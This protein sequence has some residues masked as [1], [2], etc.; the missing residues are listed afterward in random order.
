MCGKMLHVSIANDR[1]EG[2]AVCWSFILVKD[3]HV[4]RDSVKQKF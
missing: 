2:Y 4:F 1:G 3:E